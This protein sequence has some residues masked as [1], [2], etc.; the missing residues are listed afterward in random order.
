MSEVSFPVGSRD[1][2][3]M[4][5]EWLGYLRGAVVR[6]LDGLTDAQ[7]RM[8]P[9]GRLIPLLGIVHH[10]TRVEWRWID[11]GF[12]GA[13]V[14]RSEQE[15]VPDDQARIADVVSAYRARGTATD[16]AVRGLSLD[17]RSEEETWAAGHDLRWVLVHLINETARHAG[18]ADATRELIDGTTGE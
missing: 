5:L 9:Q 1:E 12:R 7:A 8:R 3:E 6:N 17:T 14:E 2:R 11:G 4:L 13:E 16:A 18:H 15:F 10:L